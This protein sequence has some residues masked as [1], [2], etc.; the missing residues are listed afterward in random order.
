MPGISSARM[1]LF[2]ISRELQFGICNYSERSTIYPHGKRRKCF[3]GEQKV[4]S[5]DRKGFMSPHRLSPSLPATKSL[6]FSLLG[7]SFTGVRAPPSGLQF[8]LQFLLAFFIFISQYPVL[9]LADSCLCL[10]AQSCPI[11]VTPRTTGPP[12]TS[13]HGDSPGK[14]TGVGSHALLRGII[15]AQGADL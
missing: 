4:E 10:V 6:V 3:Y 1:G 5:C 7:S 8:L 2:R 13:A 14:N 11:L 15:P 12:G 9:I